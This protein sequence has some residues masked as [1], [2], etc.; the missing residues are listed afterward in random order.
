MLTQISDNREEY[1]RNLFLN[2]KGESGV[3]VGQVLEKSVRV[4]VTKE[5]HADYLVQL[6]KK[7]FYYQIS[8][9]TE[10]TSNYSDILGDFHRQNIK[11]FKLDLK[12]IDVKFLTAAVTGMSSSVSVMFMNGY[13]DVSLEEY[14]DYRIKL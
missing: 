11:T 2:L 1:V 8:R 5:L 6:V 10:F 9:V 14:I 13:L 4:G 3:G 12:E 7:R